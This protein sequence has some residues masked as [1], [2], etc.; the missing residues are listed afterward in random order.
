MAEPF[1]NLRYVRV[2]IERV[3]CRRRSQAMR[4]DLKPEYRRMTPRQLVIP[5]RRD[6]FLPIAPATVTERSEQCPSVVGAVPRDLE[7]ILDQI[8]SDAVKEDVAR[9]F[10]LAGHLQVRLP[11]PLMLKIP[12]SELAQLLSAEGVVE[13]G[14]QDGSIADALERF[15][16][17]RD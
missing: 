2:V 14:G 4:A 6:C 7:I 1:L 3:R 9:L 16:V 5:I 17:W 11:S 15:L 13:Q 8:H 10:A 12:H